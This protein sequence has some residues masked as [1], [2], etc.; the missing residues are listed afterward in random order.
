[1]AD[2]TVYGFPGSTYVRTARLALEEKGVAYDIEP[3]AP[4]SDEMNALQPYGKVPAFRHGDVK[5]HETA[6]IGCYVDAA[7]DG[8]ALRPKDAKALGLMHQCISTYNDMG[9]P[10]TVPIVIQRLVVP[11][12]DGTPDEAVIE[13]HVPK[14]R[15]FLEVMD[16]ELDGNAWFA[17]SEYSLADMFPAPMVFYLSLTPEGEKMLPAFKNVGRWFEAVSARPSF[18]ATMPPQD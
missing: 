15:R 5:L 16:G 4:H 1:M 6:A 17:G 8:P 13:E 7:F 2:V 3:F 10:S 9:Y 14:A 18:A 12:N 11:R